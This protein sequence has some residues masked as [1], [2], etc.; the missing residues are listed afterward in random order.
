[1]TAKFSFKRGGGGWKLINIHPKIYYE[2]AVSN[3]FG[4]EIPYSDHE[5]I[6]WYKTKVGGDTIPSL[7]LFLNSEGL[8]TQVP[9]HHVLYTDNKELLRINEALK[10][11]TIRYT[12]EFH[13]INKLQELVKEFKQ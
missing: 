7:H 2:P 8:S 3:L 5:L 9:M 11:T 1:M 13:C 4:F 12:E 10:S 6:G